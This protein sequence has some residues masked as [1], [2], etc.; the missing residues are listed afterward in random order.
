MDLKKKIRIG[1]L[2]VQNRI[3]SHEQLLTALAEQK[4]TGRKIGRTLIDLNLIKEIEL[5][6]FLSRQLQ[7]P[8]LNISQYPRKAEVVKLL[9]ES[10]ARR[11]RVM[12]LEDND[13][14]VLLAMADPTD[15]LG[16]DE[17][18]RILQKSIRVAVVKESDLLTA[19]DQSYRHTDEISNLA[20]QLQEEIS[21]NDV[22]LGH[23]LASDEVT[24]APVVKLLQSLFEDA[25]KAN[26]SDIHIEPDES[27]LR[28]R[29]RVDGVL[30][31]QILNEISIAPAVAVRLK[32]MAGLN[33]SEKRLPQ[34]GR[35]NVRVKG[36][37]LDVRL[38]TLPVQHGESIV[39]RLLDH[40]Q[41]LLSLDALGIPADILTTFKR[42]VK[43][44]HGLILVTGPTG[45][46]KTTTLYAAL[47]E[48]ND[49]QT[50]IIT[51]E[52][53]IEYSLPRI[54]QTQ[55]NAKVGLTFAGILRSALR[56]D[57][58]I[59][60]VGEMRDT[61]TADIAIRASITGHLVFS[62]LHT[63]GAV[64]TATRLM[65]MGVEG[66]I[67]ASSLRVIMAQRLVRRICEH[68][69]EPTIPEQG[70]QIWLQ[71]LNQDNLTHIEFKQGSGCPHCNNTGYKGRI[72]V[73]EL[74]ELNALTLDALRR[75]DSAAFTRDALETPGFKRFSHCALEYAKQGLTSLS[76]VLRIAGEMD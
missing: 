58:D 44:P 6:N 29:Q 37:T 31:E 23:L 34:D 67:L 59:I 68:C 40:A 71:K 57:P 49:S 38:S 2:L 20:E 7:I 33:I 41:G 3:I 36:R 27:V 25:V 10:L 72:G 4:K 12:L 30:I 70:Q 11:F 22:D 13:S 15:L 52:D 9:P 8:F 50:K 60:L 54:N 26:A 69:A 46:G 63:N 74:L 47:N 61:E 18:S 62:T 19:I 5:L 39:M 73:Y 43:S 17:L 51:A 45:S 66:Y 35:F 21:A 24:D 76:E 16:L 53:P 55:V 75:N 28:I 56:Q 42:H 65:D 14:D 32:L 48:I 64:E 1:D